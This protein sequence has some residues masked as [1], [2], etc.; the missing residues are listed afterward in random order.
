[1]DWIQAFQKLEEKTFYRGQ[2]EKGL[3]WVSTLLGNKGWQRHIL[4]IAELLRRPE[5]H[6]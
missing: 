3:K 5:A 2:V 6:K 4:D 1:M